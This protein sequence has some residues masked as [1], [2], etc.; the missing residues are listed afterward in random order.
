MKY[1]LIILLFLGQLAYSQIDASR[2]DTK[3]SGA[4]FSRGKINSGNNTLGIPNRSKVDN[5][6]KK[7]EKGINFQPKEQMTN[8]SD[9][10]TK[11]F[12]SKPE[13]ENDQ[14]MKEE[15]GRD[16]HI[17]D[18]VTTSDKMVFMCRDHML[19]DGDRVQVRLNGKVVIENLLLENAYKEITI[20][21]EVGFNKVEFIA[22]NQGDSGPN[23]A[24][25]KAIDNGKV[26][27]HNVW[28]LLTGV[29]A[30]TV[31]VRNQ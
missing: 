7:P 22:L 2:S 10:Y 28:N 9:L 21:L 27:A 20:Q 29:K 15:F 6:F 12:N 31:I 26:I 25:F 17:G 3:N 30:S 19:F 14:K 11:K 24:E 13:N 16:M 1:F 5:I 4:V 8:P 23:T 18:F